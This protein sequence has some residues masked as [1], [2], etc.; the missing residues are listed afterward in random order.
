MK[1]TDDNIV[2]CTNRAENDELCGII[3][4]FRKCMRHV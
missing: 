4:Q 3:Q 2:W 1:L